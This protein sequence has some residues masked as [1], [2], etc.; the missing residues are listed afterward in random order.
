MIHLNIQ[1]DGPKG[2]KLSLKGKKKKTEQ[3]ASCLI[4]PISKKLSSQTGQ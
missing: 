3:Q 2:S 4:K 1:V